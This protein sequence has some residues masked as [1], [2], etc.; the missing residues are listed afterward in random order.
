MGGAVFDLRKCLPI[1]GILPLHNLIPIPQ[2]GD[3]G[4]TILQI[5]A[6][7]LVL[8]SQEKSLK[9]HEWERYG[10]SHLFSMNWVKILPYIAKSME[11][12]FPYL[13]IV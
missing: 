8:N 7:L 3:L 10:Y 13:G 4:K 5:N 12:G 9:I 2:L 1:I 11:T 6:D